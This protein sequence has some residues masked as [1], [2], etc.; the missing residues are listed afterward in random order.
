MAAEAG[1]E[2]AEVANES[3]M[4]SM[5][6]MF[7]RAAALNPFKALPAGANFAFINA[8]Q[9]SV[10]ENLAYDASIASQGTGKGTLSSE[11]KQ[12]MESE[13][14]QTSMAVNIAL[15]VMMMLAMPYSMK[16][17]ASAEETAYTNSLTKLINEYPKTFFYAMSAISAGAAA[18]Q[19]YALA[20]MS[21]NYKEQADA[22]KALG[23]AEADEKQY[24]G[25]VD[26]FN[27][28]AIDA[29]NEE[30]QTLSSR[31]K[32]DTDM[33]QNMYSYMSTYTNVI[34]QAV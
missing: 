19:T 30:E 34:N 26:V 23:Y 7:E 4:Q 2:T 32:I 6:N 29:M 9:L 33:L 10:S 17:A 8:A 24:L 28:M 5:Y 22:T 12:K 31:S 3:M 15:A 1:T 14:M 20:D 21:Y 18:A 25:L 27:Q 16:S 13:A 11:E